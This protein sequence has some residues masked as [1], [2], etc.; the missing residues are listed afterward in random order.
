MATPLQPIVPPSPVLSKIIFPSQPPQVPPPVLSYVSGGALIVP[1]YFVKIT[2]VIQ[3]QDGVLHES[4][5][6]N[7]SSLAVPADNL[8][9]VASPSAILMP[10]ALVGWN[11]YVGAAPGFEV[12]QNSSPIAIG[13]S[14]QESAP[15]LVTGAPPPTVWGNT[16]IFTFPGRNFPYT[17]RDAKIHDEF[18]TAGVQQSICWYVDNIMDFSMPYVQDGN[19]VAGWD[20]FLAYAVQRCPWDFYRD[21]TQSQYVTLIMTTTN[22]KLAYRA[23]GLWT[24]DI[25]ARQAILTQ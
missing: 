23:P 16:I 6:S 14:W 20:Q 9:V 12:L 4:L 8:L 13:T 2:W 19:D 17:N 22:P 24:V 21:S 1:K 15:G 7:E 3:T 5:P 25:K 10:Y 18:S 11:V